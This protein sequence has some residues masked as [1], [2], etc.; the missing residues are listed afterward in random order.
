MSSIGL[1]N[2]PHSSKATGK[3]RRYQPD[4]RHNAPFCERVPGCDSRGDERCNST[5]VELLGKAQAGDQQAFVDLCN[6][7]NYRL[8]GRIFGIVKNQDDVED[9]FQETLMRAYKHLNGFRGSCS[10]QTWITQIATNTALM[11][12]RRRKC[13]PERCGE[14]VG[15]EGETFDFPEVAD[16]KPNP[17]QTYSTV[18]RN[19]IV[20]DAVGRLPAGFRPLMDLYYGEENSLI[21]AAQAL[22]MTV[23]TAKSRLT[24][25]RA[26]LRRRLGNHPL[27]C[28]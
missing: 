21:D 7:H 2:S 13:C 17:E 19:S 14:F 23:A 11:L 12:L 4:S 8:K 6:R 3:V 9:I 25:A 28:I 1:C 24:R 26:L 20:S 15:K 22:G 16:P 18:Q 10:F 5:E 27:M